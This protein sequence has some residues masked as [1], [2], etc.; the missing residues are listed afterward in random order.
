MWRDPSCS[1]KEDEKFCEHYRK[2]QIDT[3]QPKPKC[4]S[5]AHPLSIY[6]AVLTCLP[7]RRLFKHPC[8]R[9]GLN[10]DL[11]AACWHEIFY[12]TQLRLPGRR[13]QM[14]RVQALS[15]LRRDFS[16]T[17]GH[18]R[19]CTYT[20]P[21]D[22]ILVFFWVHGNLDGVNHRKIMHKLV[23]VGVQRSMRRRP[24]TRR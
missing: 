1:I 8:P 11:T 21:T 13:V 7:L 23:T 2:I 19:T 3:N 18:V 4:N 5:Y 12:H 10:Y 14:H 15:C 6:P 24:A 17:E 22:Q 20:I 16:V 9:P